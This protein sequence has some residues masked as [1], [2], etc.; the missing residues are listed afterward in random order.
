[1]W[2]RDKSQWDLTTFYFHKLHRKA[3]DFTLAEKHGFGQTF[4]G[5]L[6]MNVFA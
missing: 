6:L 5:F 2:E 1:M 4:F 3:W